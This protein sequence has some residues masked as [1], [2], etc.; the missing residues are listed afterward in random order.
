MLNIDLTLGGWYTG[1]PEQCLTFL[2][3]YPSLVRNKDQLLKDFHWSINK[4]QWIYIKDMHP[5]YIRHVLLQK[6][7]AYKTFEGYR[8]IKHVLSAVDCNYTLVGQMVSLWYE[9]Y[10][11]PHDHKRE[12]M[13]TVLQN[14][15]KVH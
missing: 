8:F 9:M 2:R 4:E 7:D 12:L 6:L 15:D 14:T 1:T 13:L 3:Q 10:N 5:A 11:V